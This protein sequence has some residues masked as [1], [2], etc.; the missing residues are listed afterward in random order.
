M[1]LMKSYVMLQNASFYYF[2]V[3]KENQQGRELVKL[4]PLR[5]E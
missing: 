4:S 1:F 2:L 5:L 3:I